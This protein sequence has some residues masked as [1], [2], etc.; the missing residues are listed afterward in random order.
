M[1]P[2]YINCKTNEEPCEYLIT[3]SCPN[4]CPYVDTLGIGG[5]DPG[6]ASRLEELSKE[7]NLQEDKK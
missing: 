6:T 4:T 3:T 5:G 7:I 2:T 1:I